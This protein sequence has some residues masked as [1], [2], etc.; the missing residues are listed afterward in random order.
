[1]ESLFANEWSRNLPKVALFHDAI[2]VKFPQWCPSKTVDHFPG[3][4]E[5]LSNFDHVIC[6]SRTSQSDLLEYWDSRHISA[7]KTSVVS[8]GV[9]ETRKVI[10]PTEKIE[11]E[12][13]LTVL[14]VGTLEA[15][16][17][18][19]NLLRAAA[20]LWE[21]D[22]NFTLKLVGMINKSSGK[23]AAGL[24]A[25]LQKKGHSLSW[26]GP[27]SDEE[28]NRLYATADLFVYPSLYEGFGIPVLEALKNNIPVLTTEHG[29]LSE[30]VEGG[31]CVTCDGS[32]ESIRDAL[33]NL[34]TN[35]SLRASLEDQAKTRSI[36]KIGQTA[37]DIASILQ[38]LGK[39]RK[40]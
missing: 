5:C 19:L 15:R 20:D 13:E 4:L 33:E 29:A 7:P 18:H 1:M 39:L 27:V 31:G 24:I 22:L 10:D 3:Y 40:A 28:L 16:K 14:S 2:P 12:K 6:V 37:M 30:L 23:D 34:I 9:P 38:D 35:K 32:R 25:E 26:R 36:R 8:L 17:N 11:K 21:K